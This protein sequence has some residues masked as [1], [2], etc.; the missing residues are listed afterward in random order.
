[1]K[2]YKFY[3]LCFIFLSIFFSVFVLHK[4]NAPVQGEIY[5][6]IVTKNKVK[7]DSIK[8]E[9]V[10]FTDLKQKKNKTENISVFRIH[11]K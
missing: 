10:Y 4:I 11:H 5:S 6:N 3:V 2:N 8:N 1:M 7:V 9:R